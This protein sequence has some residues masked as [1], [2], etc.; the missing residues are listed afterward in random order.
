MQTENV[1]FQF[2]N[3]IKKFSYNNFNCFMIENL[4][5]HKLYFKTYVQ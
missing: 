4:I 2:Y 5:L 3:Y 1:C